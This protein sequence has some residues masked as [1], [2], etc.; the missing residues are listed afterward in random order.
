MDYYTVSEETGVIMDSN[1]SCPDPQEQ[2]NFFECSV[3]IIV[4]EHSGLSA[5]YIPPPPAVGPPVGKA[6]RH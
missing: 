4:G 1:S 2:A 6:W 3:Y 5:E